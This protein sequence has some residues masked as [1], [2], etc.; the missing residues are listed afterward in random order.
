MSVHPIVLGVTQQ[1]TGMLPILFKGLSPTNALH[2]SRFWNTGPVS[3]TLL[4][5]VMAWWSGARRVL[6]TGPAGPFVA[7]YNTLGVASKLLLPPD[8]WAHSD[9]GTALL[10]SDWT[11]TFMFWWDRIGNQQATASDDFLIR[12]STSKFSRS[13]CLE[14]TV[15]IVEYCV[16]RVY[17][18]STG[19]AGAN[20]S[21]W[22]KLEGVQQ[23]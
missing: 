12:K 22:S 6:S 4:P 19:R 7:S 9:Y 10:T 23:H 20:M 11:S 14:Y 8:V 18:Q 2:Y 5:T 17:Q 1:L 15:Y 13:W 3:I 21:R 16:Y